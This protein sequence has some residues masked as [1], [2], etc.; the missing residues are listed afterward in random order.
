MKYFE[1]HVKNVPGMSINYAYSTY[2][3]TPGHIIKETAVLYALKNNKFVNDGDEDCI[4]YVKEITEE[5][6]NEVSKTFQE[7]RF[8][9]NLN[10]VDS[11]LG[12]EN[13]EQMLE[14]ILNENK[15]KGTYEV[16]ENK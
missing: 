16:R 10:I 13:I 7:R 8:L 2:I 11:S 15:L 6:F 14:K 1:I 5:R 4:D 12:I 9:I 3:M